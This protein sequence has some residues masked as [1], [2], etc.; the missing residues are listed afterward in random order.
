VRRRGIG[1]DEDTAIV[2]TGDEF[3]VMGSGAVAV[4]DAG[5]ITHTNLHD[6]KEGEGLELHD[7]R[8][9]VLPAGATTASRR[10]SRSYLRAAPA[11]G[12][13]L[14]LKKHR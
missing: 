4:V 3:E 10:G 11:G 9:H 8:V 7:V 12:S 14:T 6:I 5:G 13:A 2:V 1:I